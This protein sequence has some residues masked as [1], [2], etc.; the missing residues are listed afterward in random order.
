MHEVHYDANDKPEAY[1]E[2]PAV[3]M[4]DVSVKNSVTYVQSHFS[5]FVKNYLINEIALKY[6]LNK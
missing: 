2:V 5:D 6:G 4:W 3:I 1:S